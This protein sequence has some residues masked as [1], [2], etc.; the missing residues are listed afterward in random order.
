MISHSDSELTYE[1]LSGSFTTSDVLTGARGETASVDTI[2]QSATWGVKGTDPGQLK[3]PTWIAVDS[4]GNVYVSEQK[5][6]RV[7]KFD[8]NGSYLLKL[9]GTFNSPRGIGIDSDDNVYVVDRKNHRI[10]K[11]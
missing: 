4:S 2:E 10:Q 9:D 5:Q 11:F 1:S 3:N 7:Q 6:N 8:A